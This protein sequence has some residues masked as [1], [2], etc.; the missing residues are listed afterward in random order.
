MTRHAPGL[1]DDVL[2]AIDATTVAD[3]ATWYRDMGHKPLPKK[4]GAKFPAIDWLPYQT[5]N[6]RDQELDQWFSGET[7]GVCLVLDNTGYCVLDL[8]GDLGAAQRLL[9]EAG[10]VIPDACP[11]VITGSGASHYHFTTEQ[12]V[13]RHIRLLEGN[14]AGIDLLGEGIVVAPPSIHPETGR[15]YR[16]HPPFLDRAH[17]PALPSRIRE[18]I[19]DTTR[20]TQQQLAPVDGPILKGDRERI[21]VSMLGAARRRSAQEPELRALAEAANQRCVPPL[22]CRDLDRLARSI[23]R[24]EPADLDVD[25]LLASV[26]TQQPT[27]A[28]Q[29]VT[30]ADLHVN[31]EVRV[32]YVLP[33]YLIAGT[34]TDFTGAAKI[35]KTRFRNYL[36]YSAVTGTG[37]L[38]N[39]TTTPTKVVLLTEEPP[40]SLLEGLEAAGLTDTRNVSI[41]TRYAARAADWPAIVAAAIDKARDIEARVLMVDTLP[42]LARLQGDAEN[43]SGHALAALQPLQEAD[44]PG[45]AKLVIR[46]TRKSGGGLVEA[47]RGSSAFAGE[48]DVL[49]SMT[50]PRG[51]RPSVRRLEAIGRFETIPSDMLIER[52]IVDCSTPPL[53]TDPPLPELIEGSCLAERVLA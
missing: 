5:R 48:A 38:G 8:D 1:G 34:L 40:A 27:P 17:V 46:H 10:V 30:P 18:L 22:A 19:A 47:G 4:P 51:T 36:I 43:S 52:V 31:S 21:L 24:Y 35:G 3:W 14:G 25:A 23:A 6:P 7:D 12:P 29:F 2:K 44:A 20:P 53:H 45:L 11:R 49:V 13:G 28:L 42:G 16:W 39:P 41:L 32:D 37:C 50:R 26:E 33:P 15:P 9:R